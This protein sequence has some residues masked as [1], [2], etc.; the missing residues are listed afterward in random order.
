M[1]SSKPHALFIKVVSPVG[2]VAPG[3]P[4]LLNER[5]VGAIYPYLRRVESLPNDTYEL[6]MISLVPTLV[7]VL[8]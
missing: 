7:C 2:L 3:S 4:D 6:D 1:D 8:L 5:V